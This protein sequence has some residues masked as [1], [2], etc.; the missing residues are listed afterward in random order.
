MASSFWSCS[1]RAWAAEACACAIACAA[2]VSAAMRRSISLRRAWY[3]VSIVPTYALQVLDLVADR[4]RPDATLQLCG[5]VHG[6][7]ADV[8][9]ATHGVDAAGDVERELVGLLLGLANRLLQLAHHLHLALVAIHDGLGELLFGGEDLGRVA[10]RDR[11]AQRALRLVDR[12][13]ERL[14]LL[15]QRVHRPAFE[16]RDHVVQ[17]GHRVDQVHHA[18]HRASDVLGAARDG[19]KVLRKAVAAARV[20]QRD[21]LLAQHAG[22]HVVEERRDLLVGLVLEVEVEIVAV[23]G[24]G[25]RAVDSQAIGERAGDVGDPLQHRSEERLLLAVERHRIRAAMA[26]AAEPSAALDPVQPVLALDR[27]GA[28]GAAHALAVACRA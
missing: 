8:A 2:A 15:L 24:Q 4:A 11:A 5:A 25:R 20:E 19:L 17:A 7:R 9:R 6:D 14:Q 1:T 21:H 10:A 3:H 18:L 27:V 22:E 26:V 23:A 16:H 13:V 28:D 12:D